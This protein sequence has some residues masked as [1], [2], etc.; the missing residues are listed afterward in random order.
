MQPPFID[1][2][3]F[4]PR[5]SVFTFDNQRVKIGTPAYVYVGYNV[6]IDCNIIAGLSPIAIQ[7]YHNGSLYPTGGSL[8][9]TNVT[10]TN[11]SNGDLWQCKASNSHGIDIETTIIYV[12]P[13]KYPCM[14]ALPSIYL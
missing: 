7:W 4:V 8:S 1:E 6:T 9:V 10:I 11:A 2:G 12:L 14:Y 3:S 13:S 5:P